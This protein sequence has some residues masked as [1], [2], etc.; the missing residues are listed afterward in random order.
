MVITGGH[1]GVLLQLLHVFDLASMIISPLITW[2]AG[3][4]ALSERVVLFGEQAPQRSREIEVYAEG[5]GSSATASAS[6]MSAV[7]CAWM[8]MTRSRC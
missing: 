3:A 1:V 7:G 4:M 8:I 5:L 2:S 6:P